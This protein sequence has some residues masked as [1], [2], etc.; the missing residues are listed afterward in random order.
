[1]K[2]LTDKGFIK[3]ALS[4]GTPIMLQQF[5]VQGMRLLDSLMIGSLGQKEVVAVGNAGQVSFLMYVF[6]FGAGSSAGVFTAQFWGKG[7][8]GGIK[9]T[10]SFT[11]LIALVIALP[12][13][14]VGMFIPETIMSFMNGDPEI[15]KLGAS[16]LRVDSL[17]YLFFA[18]SVTFSSVLKGTRQT[19]LPLYTNLVAVALNAFLNWVFIF[20][21]L[22]MPRLGVAGAATGTTTAIIVEFTLIYILSQR[23]KNP[24]RMRFKEWNWGGREFRGLFLRKATPILLNEM[25]WSIGNFGLVLIFNRMGEAPAACMAIFVVL[26]RMC[27]IVFNGLANTSSIFVG[28]YIGAKDEKKAY[29]YAKRF[30]LSGIVCAVVLGGLLIAVRGPV[31]SLY[32]IP[33]ATADM[34]SGV[35]IAFGCVSWLSVFNFISIIGVLRGGGDT[36]FA[37]FIDLA[38]MYL[39]SLP[40][41]Y[42]LGVVLRLPIYWV[43]LCF[44]V[45][46]DGF[47]AIL[48]V[49][50]IVSKKWINNITESNEIFE[51]QV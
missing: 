1:M 15:V 30:L 50:R 23:K 37:A 48:G 24:V 35:L 8:I 10:L 16:Y 7:D 38:G 22:G 29:D 32:N 9:R 45:A 6:L 33:P 28:N 4:I 11:L 43:Y 27:Y 3:N 34:L 17:S 39:F 26:E 31:T 44:I 2:V 51:V 36:K 21:N 46:G 12:F 47:R 41:A 18:M 14:A 42:L 5:L 20:G 25:L 13:F 19:R 40:L 49:R